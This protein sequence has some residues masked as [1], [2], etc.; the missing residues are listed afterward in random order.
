ML[1]PVSFP[2][3]SGW[4]LFGLWGHRMGTLGGFGGCCSVLWGSI[5]GGEEGLVW[6]LTG[7][8]L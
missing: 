3:R 6:V 5:R 7:E 2:G 4:G 1:D 8:R